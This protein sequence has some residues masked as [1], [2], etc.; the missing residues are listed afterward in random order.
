MVGVDKTRSHHNRGGAIA[1]HQLPTRWTH[2]ANLPAGAAA[3][4]LRRLTQY[5]AILIPFLYWI[6]DGARVQALVIQERRCRRCL[7]P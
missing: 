5:E 3:H 4:L 2:N 7:A 6:G 1:S